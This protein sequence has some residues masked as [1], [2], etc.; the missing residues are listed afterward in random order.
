ML[1]RYALIVLATMS[2]AACAQ[3]PKKADTAVSNDWSTII[4]STDPVVDAALGKRLTAPDGTAYTL[5]SHSALTGWAVDGHDDALSAFRRSCDRLENGAPNRAF[6]GVLSQRGEWELVC[7]ALGNW[8][9]SPR[10][11]WETQFVPVR[12]ETSDK[13]LFTG[14]YEPELQAS[15]ERKG[16]FQHPIYRKPPE[17]VTQGKQF[18]RRDSR[19]FR[20]HYSRAE[21]ARGALRG[22]NLELAFLADPVEA[23]FLQI[24]GSGRLKFPDGT[25]MRVGFAAKNGHPYRSVGKEMIRRG[26]TSRNKASAAAIKRFYRQDPKRGQQLLNVNASFVYFRPVDGLAP[27]DGP[28]GSLGVPLTPGRSLAVDPRYTPLGAPVWVQM[29]SDRVPLRRLMVAQDVGGA[30][31]GVQR[32]DIFFGSGR[33]AGEI[34]GR[35]KY[36]GQMV[37]LYPRATVRRLLGG[38]S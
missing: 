12:I 35:I 3:Q 14:Y 25:T 7:Q 28:I 29:T 19:G 18:G 11:F 5:L 37:V 15:R 1:G 30:I 10:A 26:W 27:A 16:P 23:F 20:P 36:P 2:L 9:G 34:A 32:G 31:K 17:L 21:I 4:Q 13:A 38:S 6:K 8:G 22:R 24:Q 33:K